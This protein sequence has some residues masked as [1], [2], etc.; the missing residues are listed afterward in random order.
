MTL[1]T[2][3]QAVVGRLNVVVPVAVQTA[4][5]MGKITT[6][7]VQSGQRK[8]AAVLQVATQTAAAAAAGA[9]V[10]LPEGSGLE[11]TLGALIDAHVALL[12]LFQSPASAAAAGAQPTAAADVP[13]QPSAESVAV[14]GQAGATG[15][16][17]TPPLE[18]EAWREIDGVRYVWDPQSERWASAGR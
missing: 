6:P 17:Q 16:L 3:F 11:T 7:G 12:K 1:E 13:S 14:G 18:G 15:D 10:A 8:R 5:V 2:G 9:G 4:E